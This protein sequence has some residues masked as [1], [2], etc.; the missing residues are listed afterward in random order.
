MSSLSPAKKTVIALMTLAVAVAAGLLAWS[1]FARPLSTEP[2]AS[3]TGSAGSTTVPSASSAPTS[4][5]PSTA[6]PTTA[7]P[8]TPP[9]TESTTTAPT[10]ATTAATA[11]T[12]AGDAAYASFDNTSTGWWFNHPAELGMDIPSTIPADIAARLDRYRG[13]WRQDTTDKVI[14]LTMDEGYE[15]GNNTTR[16]LDIAA[17]RSIKIN[18]FVT[19]DY[20]AYQP[21]SGP[22]GPELVRRMIADGHLVGSH[23]DSH[24]NQAELIATGGVQAMVD[25]MQ[26]LEVSF[27][28]AT[29]QQIA[30]FLRPPQGAYS[31]RTL[32]VLS[33]LGYRAV[34][35]SFAYRDWITTEQP[36]PAA[37]LA[38]IV[39][40][41]HPG[42]VYLLHVVSDTN[43]SILPDF[44]DA[45]QARG[46]RFALLSQI[47]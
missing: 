18:F 26:R 41:L 14:Y 30:R 16:V 7:R 2:T 36:D 3:T 19:G 42:A 45:A 21:A 47:P 24:P 39:G 13:I 1:A 5:A 10:I 33:D 28:N 17:S 44:I 8:S 38:Q 20:L 12:N 35:W 46:Y 32:K 34:M 29:G 27:T 43:V 25:D 23:T 4:T 11:G 22:G 40:E 37:A 9:P 6:A 31:E 15:K